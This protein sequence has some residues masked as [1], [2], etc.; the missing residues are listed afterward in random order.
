MEPSAELALRFSYAISSSNSIKKGKEMFFAQFLHILGFTVWVGGMFFAYMALRP[1][2]A[3]R[4]EGDARL[5]LWE[6]VLQKFFFWVWLSI[7]G[8]LFS[9]LYMMAQIGR[10]PLYVTVMFVTG[11]VMMGIFSHVFFAPYKRL[12][13]AVAANEWKDGAAALS[14]IRTLVGVNLILGLLTI[15]VGSL[16]RIVA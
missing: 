8:I 5:R 6:G 3:A 12:K 14:Q 1:I 16:G 2:A 10:P 7:A 4:L 11:I 15:A 9:G 13:R